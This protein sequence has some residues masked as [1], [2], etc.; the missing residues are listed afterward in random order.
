[1]GHEPEEGVGRLG[2][3]FE[4]L[5][6]G[7]PADVQRPRFSLCTKRGPQLGP[8]KAEEM[9][10]G[11]EAAGDGPGPW[12]GHQRA[13]PRGGEEPVHLEPQ[14]GPYALTMPDSGQHFPGEEG[15][16]HMVTPP[17]F[18]TLW[19]GQGQERGPHP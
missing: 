8:M 5:R 16:D 13:P 15:T 9:R 11:G 4:V 19:E 3:G 10:R 1:M 14:L 18:S 6:K 7:E 12:Q 17:A 2:S